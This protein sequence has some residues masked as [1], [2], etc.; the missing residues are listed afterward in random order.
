MAPK[1]CSGLELGYKQVR[2]IIW[3]EFIYLFILIQIQIAGTLIS[4]LECLRKRFTFHYVETRGVNYN[5][6]PMTHNKTLCEWEV[7]SSDMK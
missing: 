7:S 3:N 5:S 6:D 2:Y 1:W 4:G